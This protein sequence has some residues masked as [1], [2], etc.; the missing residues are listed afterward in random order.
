MPAYGQGSIRELNK[1]RNIIK[2]HTNGD[3]D[4]FKSESRQKKIQKV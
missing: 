4:P 1:E 2:E 3:N